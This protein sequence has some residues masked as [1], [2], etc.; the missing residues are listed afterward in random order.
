MK[1]PIALE[2][3]HLMQTY[4]RFPLVIERGKGCWVWDAEG[5]KYL[6]FLAGIGVNA[7]GHRH[8]GF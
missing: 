1:N 5:N 2:K 6:D 8:P 4:A 3:K 7:L